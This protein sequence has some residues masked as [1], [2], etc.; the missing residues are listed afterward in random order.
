MTGIPE[1]T[2]FFHTPGVG[3]TTYLIANTPDGHALAAAAPED[4]A[5]LRTERRLARAVKPLALLTLA[6]MGFVAGDFLASPLITSGPLFGVWGIAVAVLIAAAMIG[7]YVFSTTAH[8]EQRNALASQRHL[9]QSTRFTP[10]SIADLPL[11]IRGVATLTVLSRAADVGR[12]GAI[13]TE[14]DYPYRTHPVGIED[15]IVDLT[16]QGPPQVYNPAVYE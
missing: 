13:Y 8:S 11:T 2:R 9:A 10:A 12:L 7:A 4:S 16:R 5:W 14:L 15:V 3:T 1:P 6:A